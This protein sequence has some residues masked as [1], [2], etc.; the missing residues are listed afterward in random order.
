MSL[1]KMPLFVWMVLVNSFLIIWAMPFL[2]ADAILLLFDR[3]VGT[4]FFQPGQGGNVVMWEH[5]FWG[6]G[7]PEVYIM[8]LP[9]FGMASE[10]I[11]V[12]SRKPIFGYTFVAFSGVAIGFISFIVWAHHMFTT[13]LTVSEQAFFAATS[14]IIAVPTGVKIFNWLGTMWGGSIRWTTAMLF[15]A[16]FILQ[17]T[18]GGIS[19]VMFSVV[20]LDYAS[21][22]TYFVVAHFHYVLFGGSLFLILAGT[23]YWFPKMTGRMLS[24]RLGQ[25]AILD[26]RR[27]LQPDLLPA[28]LP[29]GDA[30][31]RLH[32]HQQR[33]DDPKTSCPPI[34]AFIIAF[35][36]VILL[37]NIIKSLR[38]G[39]DRR[40]KSVERVDA[41]VADSISATR[42][43]L[44]HHSHGAQPPS[45]LGSRSPRSA[46]LALRAPR[47]SGRRDRHAARRSRGEPF[48][49]GAGSRG[50]CR[51]YP[52]GGT[53]ASALPLRAADWRPRRV[54]PG[55][56]RR[57]RRASADDTGT[58]AD[59]VLHQLRV[60]LLRLADRDVLRVL[61]P[62][63]VSRSWIFRAP[64]GS[65]LPCSPV[66]EP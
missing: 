15:C 62:L 41:G 56:R 16:A 24:E 7:H 63:L 49:G 34:G 45:P 29:G 59:A 36:I 40:P 43:Q 13:G 39:E 31:P 50:S 57:R 22:D 53:A 48:P 37:F 32:L 18:I 58:H 33:L 17:F 4:H 66:A 46:R 52:R 47:V 27:R 25:T 20:P 19:G 61:V 2:T 65:V 60:H 1:N 35:S 26:D 5:I 23:Y 55:G 42:L 51:R 54:P 6:F 21:S 28:A 3:F 8:I 64:S 38:S 10:I 44:R 30:A 11:P 14:M 12:F 9:A